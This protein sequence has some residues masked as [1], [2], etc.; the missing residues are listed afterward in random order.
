MSGALPLLL[1]AALALLGVLLPAGTWHAGASGS[2]AIAS[3]SPSGDDDAAQ[4][5]GQA[6]EHSIV[7][8]GQDRHVAMPGLTPEERGMTAAQDSRRVTTV[9]IGQADS[10]EP[11]SMWARAP[12]GARGDG[13]AT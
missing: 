10:A 13:P 6:C 7:G 4:G 11:G 2:T 1:T 5:P 9:A 8:R 12:P 3:T